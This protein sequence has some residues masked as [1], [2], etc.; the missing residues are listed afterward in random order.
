RS[1][2]DQS[3]AEPCTALLI[4]FA[5]CTILEVLEISHET[6]PANATKRSDLRATR[7]GQESGICGRRGTVACAGHWGKHGSVQRGGCFPAQTS[8]VPEFNRPDHDHGDGS[9]AR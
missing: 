3:R 1:T 9:E 6:L 7:P 2:R 4:E 8:A 5:G